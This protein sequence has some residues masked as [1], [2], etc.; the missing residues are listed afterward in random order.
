MRSPK[1]KSCLRQQG[2]RAR[3]YYRKAAEGLPRADARRLVAPRIMGA[4]TAP[5]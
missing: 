2:Q 4:I 3:E 5:F 1:V